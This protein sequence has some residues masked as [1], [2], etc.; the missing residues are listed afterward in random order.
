ML[1]WPANRLGFIKRA[2][3]LRLNVRRL[4]QNAPR[5]AYRFMAIT[6]I[7]AEGEQYRTV[8]LHFESTKATI[9]HVLPTVTVIGAV[10]LTFNQELRQVQRQ[11]MRL[12]PQM[13]Q[14]M[15]ILQLPMFQLEQRIREELE[16]NPLLEIAQEEPDEAD[17]Y[18]ADGDYLAFSEEH[19]PEIKFD[20]N[21][22][23]EEFSIAH[24]FAQSY[25]DTIDEAPIR[26]QNWL[27]EQGKLVADTFANIESRGE[28]LQEHLIKQLDW[29]DI[30][31]PLRE[32]VL[33][34]VNCLEPSGYFTDTLENF[35]GEGYTPEELELAREALALVKRLEPAGVGG[36]D[37][38]EC[39]LLQIDPQSKYAEVLPMLIKS[40]LVNISTNRMSYISKM[41][42][43]SLDTIQ[44]AVA[45]LRHFNPRPGANFE[46]GSVAAVIPDIFVE[47]TDSGKYVVRLDE[48]YLPKLCI[49][50]GY[51]GLINKPSTGK[52]EK[53]YIRKHIGSAQWLL[54]AIEQRRDT[55]LKV[56]QAI[57]DYQTD[58]FETGQQALKPLKMQQI[59]DTVGI[60]IATVSRACDDKWISSPKGVFP[61]RR[62][63]AGG[64][65][66]SDGGEDVANDAVRS[67]IREIVDKE[68]KKS[69]LSDDAI[70]KMLQAEGIQV[71]RRTIAKYRDLLNIPS[72]RRRRQWEG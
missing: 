17:I 1:R 7:G 56:S 30:S 26:S 5:I 42:G 54:E 50:A 24:E 14:A 52:E 67:K 36:K 21:E 19:E 64:L 25:S 4:P 38:K 37:L 15:E 69:P 63:F 70:V 31:E 72:S 62:L 65:T 20:H 33:R 53:S 9:Y 12:T 28:T 32:M 51:R 6:E 68:D 49:N 16:Q 29:F 59:A 44:G 18:E 34:I 10:R 27:E 23:T 3:L 47:K 2:Q 58:F 35:L 48:R 61:L 57:V 39:L 13:I 55:L 71:A 11:E 22:G 45:E 60:H 43:L 8:I 41:T 66:S 40:H 46:R